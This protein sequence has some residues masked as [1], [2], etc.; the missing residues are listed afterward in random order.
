MGHARA[1]SNPAAVV[2][3]AKEVFFL[4][5]ISLL[6]AMLRSIL[7]GSE[8]WKEDERRCLSACPLTNRCSAGHRLG[9][10]S[11]ERS[12]QSGRTSENESWGEIFEL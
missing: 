11:Q 8:R 5:V 6:A 3:F 4:L 2:S 9:K 7:A 12:G 10:E 1:G